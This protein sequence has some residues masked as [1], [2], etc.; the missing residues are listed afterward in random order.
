MGQEITVTEQPTAKAGVIRFE[1]NRSLTGMGHELYQSRE[2]AIGPRPVDELA[3]RLF[4]HGGVDA[5]HIYSN[6]VT[7]ELAPG[8]TGDGMAD[9]IHNLFIYYRPGVPV[10]DPMAPT[11]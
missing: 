3:R 9:V 4:D 2:D 1:L 10:A 11:A 7:V 6:I 8:S 5:V